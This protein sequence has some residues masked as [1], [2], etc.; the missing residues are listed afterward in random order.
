M[1]SRDDKQLVSAWVGNFVHTALKLKAAGSGL[2]VQ[3]IVEQAL[4]EYLGEPVPF[5]RT[6]ESSLISFGGSPHPRCA[7]RAARPVP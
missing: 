7:T 5:A 3:D 1:A 6:S 4:I 2:K